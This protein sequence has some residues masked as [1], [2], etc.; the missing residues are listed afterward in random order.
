MYVQNTSFFYVNFNLVWI[1]DVE[2]RNLRKPVYFLICYYWFLRAN[3]QSRIH[4]FWLFEQ[5]NRVTAWQIDRQTGLKNMKITLPIYNVRYT[6]QMIIIY[7][8]IDDKRRYC[9]KISSIFGGLHFTMIHKLFGWHTAKP[10]SRNGHQTYC[11]EGNCK[12][13]H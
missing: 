10:T 5:R 1:I 12:W 7:Y 3:A 13:N 11:S 6:V 2:N 4:D 8:E 9:G